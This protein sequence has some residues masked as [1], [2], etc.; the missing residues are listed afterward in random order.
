MD[1][2][3][4][5]VCAVGGNAVSAFL[6]WR[7]QATNACDVTL[8][9]KSGYDS[10][11]Q[12]GITFKSTVFGNERFKPRHVVR[13]PEEA[14]SAQDAPFD[15]VLLCVKALP[16]V[17]DLAAVIESVVT[18]QHTCILLNTT[19][20][21]GIEDHI[22]E[23]YPSNVVLSLVSGAELTQL[24]AS[25]FEHKASTEI[26][27][28]PAN[29]NPSM[30][31]TIQGDMAEALA[32]TL[33]SGQVNCHVSTNI[34]QQQFERMIGPIAFH[35]AS[36]IFETPSHAELYEKTG[37]KVM[38][39]GVL[40]ELITLATAQGC[41]FPSDF[42]QKTI[43]DMLHPSDT[44]SIM[45]QDFLARRP[46]E[47]ET[48][49][50]SPMKLADRVGIKVPRIETLY[51]IL[52]SLNTANQQRKEA[53]ISPAGA[54][55]VPPP[56][57]SSR[58]GMNPPMNGNGG[59]RGRGGRAAS[60]G[61]PPGMRRGPPVSMNGGAP[62][63]YGRPN[64]YQSRNQSRRG[65]M[66][67]ENLEE[68]SHLVLY[69]DIPEASESSNVGD[70]T[71]TPID[72]IGMREREL[73]LRER[74]LAL[75]EQ[76]MRVR[77]GPA[78]FNR[79]G[80]R[81]PP[82]VRGGG[83]GGGFDDDDDD[84]E[85][86]DPQDAIVPLIDPDNFDMMSVT[87][88]RNRKAPPSNPSVLRKDPEF[89]ASGRGSSRMGFNRPNYPRNRSSAKIISSTPT[90]HDNILDDPLLAYSSNR[91]GNVDRAQMGHQSRT[92]S[93]TTAH[94]DHMQNGHNGPLGTQNGP[95]PRRASQS[96]NDAYSPQLGRGN[97]RP[98]PNGY[99]P[100]MN[101]RPSPPGMRQPV[102]RHPPG[103]GN[104][105]APQ[106]VEQYAGVSALHPKGPMSRSL[107]GSASASAESGD[108]GASANLDSEPSANSS[109][110][111]LG[112]RPPIG[113]R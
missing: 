65:S 63:G 70:A 38:I 37:A 24:G 23:R 98:S 74:E 90:P 72:N 55:G 83:G 75:K 89:D 79:R 10:V 17:Y 113:V 31:S 16:D 35:P 12:Y 26:W 85:G 40:D 88:R 107:T 3:L 20:S 80:P 102:P 87:S 78:F 14:A 28:G 104:S 62:N 71:S 95:Y 64:G 25:E 84:E 97:G 110:S 82:S 8:V 53:P 45:Y 57:L 41:S 76:E 68:F 73:M 47:V 49:L 93:L 51:A 34:R 13:A 22:E 42:K 59:G 96:P 56:R 29:K 11:A 21:L 50:G 103:Q 27:V 30:P 33:N 66:E 9:W 60:M 2:P 101:G 81:G 1:S 111:S 100:P 52:H 36:V 61:P 39:S 5:N 92:N 106:Q 58:M 86:I 94:L 112:P 46:M 19:S 4:M 99:G 108:S 15:Y 77:K 32:M 69:D 109:Q 6:S 91:Y 44:N 48:Y 43:N 67:G 54:A 105:V 18:P 7:L